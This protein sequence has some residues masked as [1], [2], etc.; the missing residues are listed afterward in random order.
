MDIPLKKRPWFIRYRYYLLAAL[1]FIALLGYAAVLALGPRKFRVDKENVQIAEVRH[2]DFLEYVDVEG[3]VHP[4]MTV[5]VNSLE[6]GSVARIVGE[7]GDMVQPGDTLL[8]L[9]NPQVERNIAD[10]LGEL[11]K[12]RIEHRRQLLEIDRNRLTLQQQSLQAEYE[13]KRLEKSY[14]LNREEYEMGIKSKAELEVAADEYAYKTRTTR[15]QR[16]N[17]HHD[18]VMGTIQRELLLRD[19]AREE[20]A[21]RREARRMEDLVVRASVAGQLSLTDI[22]PGQQ[23]SAGQRVGDVKVLD[24]FK[25]H[26]ALSEYYVDRITAGLPASLQYQERRYP[27]KVAKVWPEVKDRSFEVDLVFTDSV[28]DNVRLGKSYRLQIELGQPEKTLVVP[29]GNFY[30]VTGGRWIFKLDTDG[31]RAYRTDIGIGRQNPR[32]YELL[33]GL[34]AG[35]RVLV[36]GYQS[37]GDVEEIVLE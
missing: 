10:K 27:L 35:D 22:V 12:Q 25:I 17:L 31:T 32:Q 34:Q 36:T 20:E 3:I 9:E 13:L 14:A 5:Q 4:I 7:E 30:A 28:P 37:F 18:S 33:E 6:G 11:E 26:A 8:V 21:F 29:R 19:M 24:R 16:Q 1:A 15:L 2:T 23:I